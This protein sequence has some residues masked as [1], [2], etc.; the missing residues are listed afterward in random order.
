MVSDA[1]VFFGGWPCRDAL[2]R[3]VNATAAK[4]QNQEYAR[5]AKDF[6]LCSPIETPRDLWVLQTNLMGNVQGVVQYNAEREGITVADVCEALLDGQAEAVGV[7]DEELYRRF[8]D[9][10]NKVRFKC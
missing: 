10:S 8:V 6:H 2:A 9:L 7:E 4:M 1:L 3:A 5:L